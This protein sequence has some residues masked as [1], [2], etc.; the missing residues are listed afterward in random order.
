MERLEAER[1]KQRERDLAARKEAEAKRVTKEQVEAANLSARD[2]KTGLDLPSPLQVGGRRT[3]RACMAVRGRGGR[4]C[5]GTARSTLCRSR[6]HTHMCVWHPLTQACMHL[7]TMNMHA[8]LFMH[9]DTNRSGGVTKEEFK[10]MLYDL[11]GMQVLV[12]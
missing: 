10:Q 5:W 4:R 1:A 2:E 12:T 8:Q 7:P 9:Y 11:D 6:A 3:M